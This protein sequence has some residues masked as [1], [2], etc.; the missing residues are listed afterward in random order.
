[1][2]SIL[3]LENAF[4]PM[5]VTLTGNLIK[6]S[7]SFGST[8]SPAL[9]KALSLIFERLV[10]FV[11]VKLSR[12][13][14]FAKAPLPIVVIPTL[15]PPTVS[16]LAKLVQPLNVFCPNVAEIFAGKETLVNRVH[17]WKAPFS[18]TFTV[19]EVGHVMLAIL[20]LLKAAPRIVNVPVTKLT[21]SDVILVHDS[22]DDAPNV[23]VAQDVGHVIVDAFVPLKALSPILNVVVPPERLIVARPEHPLNAEA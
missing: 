5:L 12:F 4:F 23:Q 21:S 1:M 3:D 10:N 7:G 6:P 22:K 11:N 14:Q 9:S 2:V 20:L 8:N 16:T 17:D 13:P 18:S 19:A 15:T